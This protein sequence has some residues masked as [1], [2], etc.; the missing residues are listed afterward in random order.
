M[1]RHRDQDNL[2]KKAFN[3]KLVYSFRGPM[4]IMTESMVADRQAWS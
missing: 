3:W 1:K 2:G 4:I